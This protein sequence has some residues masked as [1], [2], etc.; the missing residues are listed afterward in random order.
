MPV[1][2]LL[3]AG[4]KHNIMTSRVYKSNTI[5]TYNQKNVLFASILLVS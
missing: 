2:L 5:D 4:L 1:K 3:C